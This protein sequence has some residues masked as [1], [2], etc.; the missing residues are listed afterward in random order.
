MINLLHNNIYDLLKKIMNIKRI[1][2]I[3]NYQNNENSKFNLIS[4]ET[5][6][7]LRSNNQKEI[8]KLTQKMKN[9][10]YI[11]K[12]IINS[13][14]EKNSKL[15]LI[16]HI[17]NNLNKFYNPTYD[18]LIKNTSKLD[19]NIFKKNELDYLNDFFIKV[20]HNSKNKDNAN[21]Y[22]ILESTLKFFNTVQEKLPISEYFH[23]PE[24]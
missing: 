23:N 18:S 11:L 15:S 24:R 22:Q 13:N 19:F 4:N 7:I 12:D 6:L 20:K 8:S 3:K 16:I 2:S 5:L 21:I 1:N 14:L 17:L 10:K 9:P